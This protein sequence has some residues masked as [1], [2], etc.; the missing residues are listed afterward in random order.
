MLD[1]ESFEASIFESF[2]IWVSDGSVWEIIQKDKDSSSQSEWPV[3]YN[4]RLE[5]IEGALITRLQESMI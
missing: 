5:F 4:D 1:K 3:G 2:K